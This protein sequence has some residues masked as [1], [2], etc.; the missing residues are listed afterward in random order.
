LPSV[1]KGGV[2]FEWTSNNFSLVALTVNVTV[3][4]AAVD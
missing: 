1:G 3:T 2:T 4:S